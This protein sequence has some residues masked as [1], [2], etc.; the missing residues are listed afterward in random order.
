MVARLLF[1]LLRKL[2]LKRHEAEVGLELWVG[3]VSKA[4]LGPKNAGIKRAILGTPGLVY[5]R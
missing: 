5:I 2:N 1:I 3:I 4:G